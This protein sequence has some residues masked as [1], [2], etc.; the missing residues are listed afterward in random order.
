MCKL[1]DIQVEQL[2]G[3]TDLFVRGVVEWIL[4]HCSY[5]EAKGNISDRML[6]IKYS[7]MI[8]SEESFERSMH[9]IKEFTGLREHEFSFEKIR[10]P[11]NQSKVNKVDELK[12]E[13]L[14]EIKD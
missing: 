2:I 14:D 5:V 3:I 12:N 11:R 6:L 7:E 9:K 8:E 10:K 13:E 1:F 4:S